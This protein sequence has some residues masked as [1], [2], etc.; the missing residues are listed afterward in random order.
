MTRKML[1]AALLAFGLP[2]L[3]GCGTDGNVG[4][5][6]LVNATTDSAT[7]DLYDGSDAVVTGVASGKASGYADVKNGTRTLNVQAGDT[8]LTKASVTAA[9]STD[10]HYTL[11][12]YV[13]GGTTQTEFLS[14]EEAAPASGKAE[15]RVLNGASTDVGTVDVYLT[16]TDCSALTSQDGTIVTDLSGL[17]DGFQSFN[18]GTFNICVT[19]AGS[20]SDVRMSAN[21]TF[22]AGEI[23]TLVLTPA[24]GGVL[25]DGLLLPQQGT[26]QPFANT[27][28]RVRLVSDAAASTDGVAASM[29]SVNLGSSPQS[30]NI[31]NYLPVTAGTVTPT[32][33]I[34]GTAVTALPQT[35]VAGTDYTLL[36]AGS[37][38]DPRIQLL[39][40]DNKPSTDTNNTTKIRLVNGVNGADAQ[41][42][43]LSLTGSILVS[44]ITFMQASTESEVAPG[45]GLSL[46]GALNGVTIYDSVN[47]GTLLANKN[48]T[49][50]LLGDLASGTQTGVLRPDN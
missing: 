44:S 23:A 9:V 49:V 31:F 34:G 35:L 19:T 10:K 48:Y 24:S 29:G 14:E 41:L 13:S 50:F 2:L 5:V 6:R 37:A 27:L 26:P 25:V 20:K 36:V 22:T 28:S 32:I 47:A 40:D 18:A 11:V 12:A 7:I 39:T 4:H 38:A 8:G 43:S 46:K 42:G 3:N 1:A 16:A 15:L 17:Q 45:T 30:P 33:T 21:I